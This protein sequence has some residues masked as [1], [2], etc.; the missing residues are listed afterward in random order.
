MEETFYYKYPDESVGVRTV[1]GVEEVTHPPGVTL[2]TAEDYQTRL[3]EI[4]AQ[5]QAD[6]AATRASEQSQ[7]AE[8]YE[9]L[10]AAGIPE[11]TAR[12][13]SGHTPQEVQ[14]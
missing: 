8:D 6:E 12:R 11:A 9:A 4:E 13:L 10:L 1:V 5:R 7:R 14:E 3:A 2:I